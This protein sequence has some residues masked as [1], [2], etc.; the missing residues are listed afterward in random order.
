M[1]EVQH[2]PTVPQKTSILGRLAAGPPARSRAVYAVPWLLA[3]PLLVLWSLAA[4]LLHA[5]AAWALQQAGGLPAGVPTPVGSG[6]PPALQAW[7]RDWADGWLGGWAPPG[8]LEWLA[9][10]ADEL[11]ASLQAGV[12]SSLLPWLQDLQ[13]TL[14]SLSGG[15]ELLAWAMWGLG[16]LWLLA[17]AAACHAA[18]LFWRR[19]GGPA[20]GGF[21]QARR[22]L[23]S[24]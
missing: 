21:G 22:G 10:L 16:S 14:P 18:L 11:L 6:L 7:L 23:G 12:L 3:L 2:D 5:V 17:M 13:K 8:L 9:G 24:H 20:E 4:W 15:L 19:R 1:P